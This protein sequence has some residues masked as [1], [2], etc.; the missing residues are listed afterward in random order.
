MSALWANKEILVRDV[1]QLSVSLDENGRL[2]YF[3]AAS[4]PYV[5]RGCPK[6]TPI[7]I[8]LKPLH[9]RIY[10][11]KRITWNIEIACDDF[12]QKPGPAGP[13]WKHGGRQMSLVII[14]FYDH[15][16]NA[17]YTHLSR[18]KPKNLNR[19]GPSVIVYFSLLCLG[20]SR[21]NEKIR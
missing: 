7:I 9:H 6:W 3:P 8:A 10:K 21:C 1:L 19:E 2:R 5:I 18:S 17:S 15:F 12:L 20:L 13:L 16:L 4:S 11:L 14:T